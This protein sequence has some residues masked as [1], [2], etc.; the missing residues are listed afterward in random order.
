MHSIAHPGHGSF[1]APPT[2]PDRVRVERFQSHDLDET[3]A[4]I[5]GKFG[6]RSRVPR[7]V[8]AFHYAHVVADLGRLSIGRVETALPQTLRAAA[9]QPTLFLPLRRG[10][11][12]RIGRRTLRSGPLTAVLLAP[13]H[14]YTCHS[15]AN[16]WVGMVVSGDLLAE[17]IAGVRRGRSRPWH[18]RS[19][20]IPLTPERRQ[21]L[22]NLLA[23]LNS[24]AA[25]ADDT[26]TPGTVDTAERGAAAWLAGMIVERSGETAVAECTVRRFE[27]LERWLDSHLE[28]DITLDLLC[29][30]SGTCG[31]TL[32][33]SAMTLRGVSPMEWVHARRLAACRARLL[34]GPHDVAISR[35]ALDCG[36]AHQGRFSAA[37]RNA[38]GELPSETL[39]AARSRVARR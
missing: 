15:P 34:Q 38:F 6:D 33:K 9:Q 12:Y 39:A 25:E 14:T 27:Q 22:R 5:A 19:I 26:A 4:Y 32:Q 7:T 2:T 30:V 36:I 10:D 18:F 28:D 21:E 17:A 31:R 20:E 13:G 24:L 11:D 29:A 3:R 8:G 37:Y 23:R 35:V 1:A 16:E